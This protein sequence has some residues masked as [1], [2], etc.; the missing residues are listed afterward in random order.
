MAITAAAQPN[1]APSP[2]AVRNVMVVTNPPCEAEAVNDL[3]GGSFQCFRGLRRPPEP[4]SF[5]RVDTRQHGAGT[6]DA[7]SRATRRAGVSSVRYP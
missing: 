1:A 3:Q 7:K 4:R 6:G 2:K 5:L